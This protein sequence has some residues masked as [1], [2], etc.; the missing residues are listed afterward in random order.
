MAKEVAEMSTAE[1]VNE[2]RSRLPHA[3]DVIRSSESQ[4]LFLRWLVIL[5]QG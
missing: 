1:I 4:E 2:R 5:D 3:T